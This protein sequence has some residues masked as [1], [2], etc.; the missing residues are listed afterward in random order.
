ML[1]VFRRNCQRE[2][3]SV[4]QSTL[5]KKDTFGTGTK[6]RAPNDDFPLITLKTLFR[7]SRVL[8]DL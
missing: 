6:S 2:R 3:T 5:S 4:I 8:L 7:L 1:V